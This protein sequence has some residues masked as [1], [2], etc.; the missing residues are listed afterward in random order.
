MRL[1]ILSGLLVACIGTSVIA[2]AV[3]GRGKHDARVRVTRHVDG[4]VFVVKTSLTRATTIEFEEGERI[5]SIVAGDTA[6]FSFQ[7]IPGDR[8]FAIKP[9]SR[10]VKTNV[11]VYTDRRSYYFTLREGASPF[12]VVR[13]SYPKKS[14]Q[15]AGSVPVRSVQNAN[16]G[17]NEENEITPLAVWD[18]GAFTFCKVRPNAPVPALFKVR[19]GRERSVNSQ[20]V[21][22]RV[23]RVSGT[24]EQW[25]LRL[26]DQE[27]YIAEML[28]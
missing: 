21:E 14:R 16:Y 27:V 5:V 7:S 3:P 2:E 4:Q 12:Y 6:S 20:T 1:G 23:L 24:S 9:T 18:D 26:G 28:K 13:F 8:V 11:T 22:R 19:N 25:A 10:G 15:S 17:A